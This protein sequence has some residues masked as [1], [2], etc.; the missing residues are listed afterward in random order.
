M[1]NESK[2]AAP[3][4]TTMTRLEAPLHKKV[5][6]LAEEGD[7]SISRQIRRLVV[8]GLDHDSESKEEK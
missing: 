3:T 5:A 1:S 4:I 8:I 6:R 2:T 7:R